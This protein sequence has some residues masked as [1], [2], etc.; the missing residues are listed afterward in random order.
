MTLLVLGIDIPTEHSFTEEGLLSFFKKLE[1]SLI[2]YAT[3]FVMVGIYWIQNHVMFNFLRYINRRLILLNLVFLFPITLLPFV[4]KVKALYRYDPL[5]VVIFS[6]AHIICG[7]LLMAMW[8][9]IVSHPELLVRP[10][11]PQ[12]RRSMAFRILIP[13]AVSLVDDQSA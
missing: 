3:S 12:V 6:S 8:A 7:L 4:A 1:P 10:V 2:A 11:T 5:V 13:P 9:Y